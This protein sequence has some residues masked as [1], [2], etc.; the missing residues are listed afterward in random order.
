MSYKGI[1]L[2]QIEYFLA[3]AEYLS[4]TEAAKK[5]YTS[6]PS[7]SRQISRMEDQLD[8]SLFVRSKKAVYMT[9]E[10]INLYNSLRG[11]T[12]KIDQALE[13]CNSISEETGL[14]IRIGCYDAMDAGIYLND[15]IRAFKQR[16]PSVNILLE[17]HSFKVLRNKLKKGEIDAL[18]TF[19]FEMS[20]MDGIIY[21]PIYSHEAS[22]IMSVDH[23]LASKEDLNLHDFKDETFIMLN[24]DESPNGYTGIIDLFK[25]AGF[26]PKRIKHVSNAESI[27][28]TVES[29]EGVALMDNTVRLYRLEKFRKYEL[30]NG[31]VSSVIAWKDDNRNPA[32]ALFY[33]YV[34]S[35]YKH[36]LEAGK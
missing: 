22:I 20:G 28:L 29:G 25:Y 10:G 33:D 30:E 14:S 24:P 7:L 21:E 15:A 16:H 35:N 23:P 9:A 4:F 3:V 31:R 12:R 34:I 6:Q 11:I 27:V 19:E 36:A 2:Q 32:L 26:T 18:F 8:V 1:T 5:M 17:R 13:S